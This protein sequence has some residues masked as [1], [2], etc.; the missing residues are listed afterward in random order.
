[1]NKITILGVVGLVALIFGMITPEYG[2]M[3]S[4]TGN[5]NNSN[6]YGNNYGNNNDHD[7]DE[8]DDHNDN[9]HNGSGSYSDKPTVT[10]YKLVIN[11]Q[12]NPIPTMTIF[13]VKLNDKPV[14]TNGTTFTVS[15]NKPVTLTESGLTGY[16][17]VEIRGDGHCPENLGG[18]ITLDKGQRIKCY[19]VNQPTPIDGGVVNDPPTVKIYKVVTNNQGNPTPS[20]ASFGITLGNNQVTANGTQY[21]LTSNV[22]VTLSESGLAGFDFVEIRGDGHCPENLGGT[23]TLDSGQDIECYIVNQPTN[24]SGPIQPGVIFHYNTLEFDRSD[25]TSGDSCSA[26]GK[27]DPCI[28]LA[29]I[30]IDRSILVVDDELKT[31]TTIVLFSIVEKG[32]IDQA[33]MQFATSPLCTLSGMGPHTVDYAEDSETFPV[34]NPTGKL[35]FE[36]QC[37]LFEASAYKVSYALIETKR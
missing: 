14:T 13:G 12:G 17:F 33:P 10:V 25:P 4:A 23:I 32:K 27:T 22:P 19:I 1:M 28:E 11:N 8:H 3:A 34:V 20:M 6:N 36:F 24:P 35:G 30:N 37:S 21:T 15:Q 18:T 2:L 31:D 7:D 26:P 16:S 29:N 5:N 9:D